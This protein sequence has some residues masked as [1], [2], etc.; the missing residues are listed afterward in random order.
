MWGEVI[1]SLGEPPPLLSWPPRP[2]SQPQGVW[3]WV[4]TLF[5]TSAPLV[6][7]CRTHAKPGVRREVQV[8]VQGLLKGQWLGRGA[9]QDRP[10]PRTAFRKQHS[11]AEW[12]RGGGEG[13]LGGGPWGGGSKGQ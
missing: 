2:L 4:A 9:G 3:L 11:Q 1:E 13:G 6:H 5:P 8:G 10:G 12:G 7:A